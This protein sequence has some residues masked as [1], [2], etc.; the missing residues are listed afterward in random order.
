MWIL[1]LQ[2][3]PQHELK[4]KPVNKPV[5]SH[6]T[7]VFVFSHA[8]EN[9]R[10]A[11]CC[12]SCVTG[13]DCLS[14]RQLYQKTVRSRNKTPTFEF[15]QSLVFKTDNTEHE[16]EMRK[17]KILIQFMRRKSWKRHQRGDDSWCLHSAQISLESAVRRLNAQQVCFTLYNRTEH[18]EGR[19]FEDA[20]L[21]EQVFLCEC[22][23]VV[24]ILKTLLLKL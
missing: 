9:G 6:Q 24:R 7:C 23:L 14:G 3:V 19:T 21:R 8:V 18:S 22:S 5:Q 20:S 15:S 13:T 10:T 12:R 16:A 4:G 1:P 17:I 2:H 11:G